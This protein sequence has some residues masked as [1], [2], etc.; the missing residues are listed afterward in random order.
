MVSGLYCT[1]FLLANK[2]WTRN[3]PVSKLVTTSKRSS[4]LLYKMLYGVWLTVLWSFCMWC[5]NGSLIHLLDTVIWRVREWWCMAL[6]WVW[7]FYAWAMGIKRWDRSNLC[8]IE[9]FIG[10][11]CKKN[12]DGR[13]VRVW[14]PKRFGLMGE[15]SGFDF[16]EDLRSQIFVYG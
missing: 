13:S 14:L 4:S 15:V 2:V 1:S 9:G 6:L 8:V 12:F 5:Y 11:G 3:A 10:L 7:S 16:L